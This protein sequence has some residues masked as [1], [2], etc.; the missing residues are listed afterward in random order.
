MRKLSLGPDHEQGVALRRI[1]SVVEC[2]NLSSDGLP[3][4]VWTQGSI[5]RQMLA[6][7]PASHN[8]CPEIT[9]VVA[10]RAMAVVVGDRALG[11]ERID[12]GK[13]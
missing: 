3:D 2:A 11:I 6:V 8:Q 1:G 13:P 12:G 9:S 7:C 10:P 4:E 5:R